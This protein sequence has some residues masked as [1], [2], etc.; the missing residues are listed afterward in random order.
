[1]PD[2]IPKPTVDVSMSAQL[3]PPFLQLG[4]KITFEKTV[5]TTKAFYLSPPTGHI[6]LA[7]KRTSTN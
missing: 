4:S 6:G 2:L 1:M 5:S 3:L 7:T